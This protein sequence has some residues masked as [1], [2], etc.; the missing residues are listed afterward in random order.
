MKAT[1]RSDGDGLARDARGADGPHALVVVRQRGEDCVALRVEGRVIHARHVQLGEAAG[2]HRLALRDGAHGGVD[3]LDVLVHGLRYR[4]ELLLHGTDH[5]A[6]V[7]HVAPA[8]VPAQADEATHKLVHLE[9][10]SPVRVQHVEEARA[11]IFRHVEVLQELLRLLVQDGRV[12]DVLGDPH[13]G[14][15]ANAEGVRPLGFRQHGVLV[16]PELVHQ[17]AGLLRLPLLVVEPVAHAD[18]LVP[19]GRGQSVVHERSHD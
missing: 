11:I 12:E 1:N 15:R 16:L 17:G 2:A 6:H 18:A 19:P 10:A 5:E 4:H 3:R 14:H 7:H 9:G 13:L 8:W